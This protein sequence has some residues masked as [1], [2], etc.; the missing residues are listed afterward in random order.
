MA[1]LYEFAW[2][3]CMLLFFSRWF[4]WRWIIALFIT[5]EGRVSER[6]RESIYVCQS[7][8]WVM[9]YYHFVGVEW[10]KICSHG[11]RGVSDV[12]CG[13]Y[14]RCWC[15]KMN[16]NVAG[17]FFLC[18]M[19][20]R[21]K[22][23][24]VIIG[25]NRC[26]EWFWFLVLSLGMNLHIGLSM[27]RHCADAWLLVYSFQKPF[28][29][30]HPR[31]FSPQIMLPIEVAMAFEWKELKVHLRINMFAIKT[32]NTKHCITLTQKQNVAM[33]WK[34]VWSIWCWCL[35][36]CSNVKDVDDIRHKNCLNHRNRLEVAHC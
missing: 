11:F 7:H 28:A 27:E 13:T 16:Q 8:V 15:V 31:C 18:D 30:M 3:D 25:I 26:L 1:S 17:I 5:V 23:I 14:E 29:R 22:K 9:F 2:N 6:E 20:F 19:Q 12:R 4:N 35:L 32:Q 36:S 10:V 34:Y 33:A 24:I 21:K